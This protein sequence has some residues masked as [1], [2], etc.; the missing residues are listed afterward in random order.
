[1]AEAVYGCPPKAE[2]ARTLATL[3]KPNTYLPHAH[4]LPTD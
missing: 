1:L 3:G 4:P 2:A